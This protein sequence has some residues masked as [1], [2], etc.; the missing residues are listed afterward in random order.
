MR[1]VTPFWDLGLYHRYAP[2]LEAI[3]ENVDLTLLYL[4]G[5]EPASNSIVFQR[6]IKPCYPRPFDM[7][8]LVEN[9][10]KQ[11]HDVDLVYS[12]SGRWQQ[13][14]GARLA[15][16]LKIP[17][18]IRLRGADEDIANSGSYAKKILY[19]LYFK[20]RITQSWIKAAKI[21]PIAQHLI[22]TL[23][24]FDHK[25]VTITVPNG[26]NLNHFNPTPPPE[27]LM[28]GY[29]GRIS[30][31]KGSDFM[32]QLIKTTP[33]I[34]YKLAGPI[35][36]IWE[37]LQNADTL[38]NIQFKDIPKIYD[39]SNIIMLPSYHEGFP[40]ILLE[41]YASARPVL[42]SESA[43]PKEAKLY[44]YCLPHDLMQ[45]FYKV[46]ELDLDTLRKLGE[47]ARSYVSQY[48][49]EKYGQHM[50]SVF[51]EAIKF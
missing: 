25:T 35:Q 34:R 22:E 30:Q 44:G 21:I 49:W 1:V 27:K 16:K 46:N 3:A 15:E 36:T 51:E 39:Q 33:N 19:H 29:V 18:V 17:H 50:A 32:H 38:G 26:V 41:A 20:P 45:W 31:E 47:E 10:Y 8:F 37:P 11:V 42:I 48:S 23:P 14:A 7:M 4:R 28:I 9:L 24:E 13:L 43:M 6:V 40:N 5:V 2:Q 12:L